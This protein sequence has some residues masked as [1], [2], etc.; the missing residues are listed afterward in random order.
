MRFC[1]LTI[2][3]ASLTATGTSAQQLLVFGDNALPSCAQQCSS[4]VQAQAACVPP[5][6]PVTDQDTYKSCFCQSGYLT[7]LENSPGTVCDDVCSATDDLTQIAIW[8]SKNCAK[9]GVSVVQA[10][11]SSQTT[12][13]AN[14]VST[15]TAADSASTDSTIA[16][17][18]I[19]QTQKRDT[20]GQGWWANHWKWV[21]M[22]IIIFVGLGLIA[23]VAV[24][25]R[26]RHLRKQDS[27]KGRFNDG[28][29]TR[30][31]ATTQD[32]GMGQSG[33]DLGGRATPAS[34][35]QTGGR[36]NARFD[37]PAKLGRVRERDLDSAADTYEGFTGSSRGATPVYDLE[38][39]GYRGKGK[40]RVRV[41][42]DEI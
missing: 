19:T 3:L 23:L 28:I 7:A 36:G 16:N 32:A 20:Q 18:G 25:I 14:S 9:N 21:M 17:S 26:R 29:T 4:L 6:G 15:T 37:S 5:A 27:M 42:H 24:L 33:Y 38:G 30:S 41:D 8:Y 13:A 22:V 2:L 40:N 10:V 34:L 31:T 35:S 1:G 39:N 12:T 11:S